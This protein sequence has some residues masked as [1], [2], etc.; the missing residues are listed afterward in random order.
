MQSQLVTDFPI[1]IPVELT[2]LFVY[3]GYTFAG[4]VLT[5]VFGLGDANTC[6]QPADL[7]SFLYGAA[8][9]K[10][11]DGNPVACG[12]YGQ[13]GVTNACIEYSPSTDSWVDTGYSLSVA[14]E[15]IAAAEISD[16]RWWVLGGQGVSS[17]SCIQ[18]DQIF[19]TELRP[20]IL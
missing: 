14:K 13:A 18:C 7:P 20:N 3:G 4:D 19:R 9:L 5:E 8:W 11:S 12:G 17:H 15:N 6:Q 16:R 2:N 10:S 1:R